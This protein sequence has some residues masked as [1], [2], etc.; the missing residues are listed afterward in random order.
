MAKLLTFAIGFLL[1]STITVLASSFPVETASVGRVAGESPDQMIDGLQNKNIQLNN[2]YVATKESKPFLSSVAP[3]EQLFSVFDSITPVTRYYSVSSSGLNQVMRA[4]QALIF[5]DAESNIEYDQLFIESRD[6]TISTLPIND[7]DNFLF[8]NIPHAGLSLPT[9]QSPFTQTTQP[10]ISTT[11]KY[12]S[13]FLYP[14]RIACSLSEHALLGDSIINARN[15]YYQD[16]EVSTE[17]AGVLLNSYTLKGNPLTTININK[18]DNDLCN[19]NQKLTRQ[20]NRLVQDLRQERKLYLAYTSEDEKI[21]TLTFPL[22]TVITNITLTHLGDRKS[23]EK[24]VACAVDTPFGL[25]PSLGFAQDKE[26]LQVQINP[27]ACEDEIEYLDLGYTVSFLSD[28]ATF[29]SHVELPSQ[30]GT[31]EL[32]PVEVSFYHDPALDLTST[33]KVYLNE[34]LVHSKKLADSR[35]YTFSVTTGPDIGPHQIRVELLDEEGN[36]RSS[37]TEPFFVSNIKVNLDAETDPFIGRAHIDPSTE[38]TIQNIKLTL[39]D[40]RNEIVCMNKQNQ[41][42]IDELFTVTL[43]CEEIFEQGVYNLHLEIDGLVYVKQLEIEDVQSQEELIHEQFLT[44]GLVVNTISGQTTEAF[45]IKLPTGTNLI[46]ANFDLEFE[47]TEQ[48]IIDHL[49]KPRS[50]WIT[51]SVQNIGLSCDTLR[52]I[53]TVTNEPFIQYLISEDDKTCSID[54]FVEKGTEE[55]ILFEVVNDDSLRL[56]VLPVLTVDKDLNILN[57]DVLFERRGGIYGLKIDGDLI[58]PLHAGFDLHIQNDG[59]DVLNHVEGECSL[60]LDY[61]HKKVIRCQGSRGAVDYTFIANEPYSVRLNF[62]FE[63][64]QSN[65]MIMISQKNAWTVHTPTQSKQQDLTVNDDELGVVM[66]TANDHPSITAIYNAGEGKQAK[67]SSSGGAFQLFGGQLGNGAIDLNTLTSGV[68][69]VGSKVDGLDE[70]QMQ[71]RAA[72]FSVPMS[73]QHSGRT[74]SGKVTMVIGRGEDAIEVLIENDQS[75]SIEK[76]L[77]K[78]IQQFSAY[79][80]KEILIPVRFYSTEEQMITISN[81]EIEYASQD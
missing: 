7:K 16:D 67:F 30:V 3:Q 19:E 9:L 34:K 51:I 32:I 81:L 24:E 43:S 25:N 65:D 20:T 66:F 10:T 48:S 41:V 60:E 75:V 77:T 15:N 21:K 52:V 23:V 38:V 11:S 79:G 44:D 29:I 37:L 14:R 55:T 53:N 64:D 80:K 2:I 72:E 78:F 35:L 61:P 1:L 22:T 18:P 27:F 28:Q 39:I 49:S 58:Y 57:N 40:S 26:L 33:L 6:K 68:I 47:G 73:V 4:D 46:N 31:N 76:E 12:V 59:L 17:M 56:P 63:G 42:T 74:S 54:L 45:T 5:V 69:L 36:V 13:E 8:L 71:E 70:Q 62:D 50:E